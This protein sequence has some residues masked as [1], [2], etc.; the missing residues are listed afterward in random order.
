MTGNELIDQFNIEDND[1]DMNSG[2]DQDDYIDGADAPA[3]DGFKLDGYSDLGDDNDND[4]NYEND[5]NEAKDDD[6]EYDDNT[7]TGQK[8]KRARPA[9]SPSTQ[10]TDGEAFI[11]EEGTNFLSTVTPH[12]PGTFGRRNRGPGE[13][14]PAYHRKVSATLDSD[15][16]LMMKMREKGFSDRQ[17]AD[18]LAKDG[19]VRYDQKSISTR[20]M[21]IR[22]AQAGN[23]DFLLKE[24][25]KEWEFKDDCLLMQAYALADIEVS[26]ELERIRAWRFRKVSEYMRRLNKATLFSETAC[27]ERYNALVEGTARIPTDLDDDPDTRRAEMEAFREAREEIRF[28]EQQEKEMQEA[29][30]RIAKDQTKEKNAQKA[31]EAAD[32]RAAKETGK[33]QRAMQR[34]AKAQLR[35]QRAAENQQA[36]TQRNAQIKRQKDE[37]EKRKKKVAKVDPKPKLTPKS[38]AKGKEAATPVTAKSKTAAERPDPRSFLSLRDLAKLCADR[39]IST[40]EKTKAQLLGEVR[41]ADDEW[42]AVELKKMCKSKGLSMQGSKSV[43]RHQLALAAAQLFP[44]FEKVADVGESA[45]DMGSGVE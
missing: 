36:K 16:E 14:L 38:K 6:S 40:D 22:L 4:E 33:A 2:G 3:D 13:S 39:G 25:Y 17:I 8:R 41:D 32:K 30:D 18:K 26:Y 19:R 5:D 29:R 21:R 24:G 42:T 43:M 31:Q 34:A 11:I 10:T 1:V 9:F 12:V 27:R 7:T 15:D 45:E 28:K 35:A 44:S 20:I 23:V 37:A